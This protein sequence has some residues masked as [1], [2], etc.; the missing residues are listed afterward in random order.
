M[1][2][3]IPSRINGTGTVL[4]LYSTVLNI[5]WQS[6]DFKSDLKKH[7]LLFIVYFVHSLWPTRAHLI[8]TWACASHFGLRMR[9]SFWL[10]MYISLW[11]AHAHF[12]LACACASHFAQRMRVSFWPAYD[13]LILGCACA[14]LFAAHVHLIF[15]YASAFR[16]GLHMRIHFG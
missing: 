12:I 5:R 2:P 9:V 15:A 8:M 14:S 7:C 3:V 13:H 10:H 16:F 4:S 6:A 11:P 1:T